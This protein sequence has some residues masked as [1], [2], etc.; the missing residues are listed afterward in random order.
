MDVLSED[1]TDTI[2]VGANDNETIDIKLSEINA[3]T[4]A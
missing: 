4:W 2:Q 1:Q 3:K